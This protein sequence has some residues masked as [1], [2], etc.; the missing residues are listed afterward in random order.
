M[1]QRQTMAQ[2]RLAVRQQRS[3]QRAMSRQE[4]ASKFNG[5][6][7]KSVEAI[8]EAA[9][10][11][12]EAKRELEADEFEAMLDEDLLVSGGTARRI[13]CIGQ[14]QVLCSH[15]NKLPPHWG[16]LYELSQLTDQRLQAAIEADDINPNMERKDAVALKPPRRSR[17]V[18]HR[19]PSCDSASL[20]WERDTRFGEIQAYVARD[21]FIGPYTAM[22]TGQ[23][24]YSV[25]QGNDPHLERRRELGRDLTLKQAKALAQQDYERRSNGHDD[26]RHAD[27]VEEQPDD[28]VEETPEEEIRNFPSD[29]FMMQAAIVLEE[30]RRFLPSFEQWKTS[31]SN[32][33]R[34]DLID[35]ARSTTELWTSVL[36]RLEENDE[37]DED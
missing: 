2:R 1:P 36:Q 6:W 28:Y 15:V 17:P 18:R 33:A 8:F 10:F 31:R 4:H 25:H 34:R 35:L 3:Q 16:T 30:L 21:Y 24:A 23:R 12:I 19:S 37:Q 5:A 11:L 22:E 9:S 20:S 27:H 26:D 7:R 29:R 13:I 14:N 32:R